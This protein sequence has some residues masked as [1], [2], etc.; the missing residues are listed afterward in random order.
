MIED[1]KTIDAGME[2]PH[3]EPD[4]AGLALMLDRAIPIMLGLRAEVMDDFIKVW[5][6]EVEPDETNFLI[7]ARF[8]QNLDETL[9]VLAGLGATLELHEE[10]GCHWASVHINGGEITTTETS[11]PAMAGAFALYGLLWGLTR[12]KT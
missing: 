9:N 8:T 1:T 11:S 5:P 2:N 7:G 3:A 10:D 12:G 4:E 6:K